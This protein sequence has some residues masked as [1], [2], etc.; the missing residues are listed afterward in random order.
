M[1]MTSQ[2]QRAAMHA[3]AAGKSTL[4]IPRKVGREFA[5]ADKGGKLPKR[6]HK[7]KHGRHHT[8]L[9]G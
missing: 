6:K 7:S 9:E 8:I 2:V 5:A 4:A 3:A 1:P